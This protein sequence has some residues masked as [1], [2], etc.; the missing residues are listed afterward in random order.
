MPNREKSVFTGFKDELLTQRIWLEAWYVG[1]RN[2][3]NC[4]IYVTLLCPVQ[5]HNYRAFVLS[6]TKNSFSKASICVLIAFIN[7]CIVG[8]CKNREAV[9]INSCIMKFY[10]DLIL[11]VIQNMCLGYR[12]S[13]FFCFMLDATLEIRFY[14]NT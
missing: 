11:K 5:L 13:N 10:V 8:Y 9:L 2:K 4:S 7:L 6:Y 12:H 14:G 1:S 3:R